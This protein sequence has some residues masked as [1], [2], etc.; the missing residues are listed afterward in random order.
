MP[1]FRACVSQTKYAFVEIEA[2]NYDDA[3]DA[4]NGLNTDDL[5]WEDVLSLDYDVEYVVE[6]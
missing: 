4:A 6:L 1:L 2:D 5:Q 3:Y